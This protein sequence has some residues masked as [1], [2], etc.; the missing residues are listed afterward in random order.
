MIVNHYSF[1]SC[2]D[3]SKIFVHMFPDGKIAKKFSCRTTKCA[4]FL[5]FGLNPHFQAQLVDKIRAAKCCVTFDECMNNISQN[6]QMDL[7]V[8]YWDD[9]SSGCKVY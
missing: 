1:N 8:R 6:E 9:E 5:C 3:I 2:V 7:I 4:Y